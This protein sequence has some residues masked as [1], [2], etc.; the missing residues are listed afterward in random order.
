TMSIASA[1]NYS[2]GRH[3]SR[4]FFRG[5]RRATCHY[6]NAKGSYAEYSFIGTAI[7]WVGSKN[8]NKGNAEV[9]ID[10]VLRKSVD[11]RGSSWVPGQVLYEE[12]GLPNA[13]HTIKIV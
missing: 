2:I 7:R 12:S 3:L 1:S 9:Y 8:D 10:G 5:K 13:R 6:S 11:T 4:P